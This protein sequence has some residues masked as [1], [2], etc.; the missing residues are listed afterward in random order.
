MTGPAVLGPSLEIVDED[1]GTWLLAL[2]LGPDG[3]V[4]AITMNV[5]ELLALGD[6][7][8]TIGGAPGTVHGYGYDLAVM[9]DLD[10]VHLLVTGDNG[11]SACLVLTQYTVAQIAALIAGT[12]GP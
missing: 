2:P 12:V 7:L 5:D 10:E 9:A 1:D 11:I 6:V 4:L 3:S 8:D